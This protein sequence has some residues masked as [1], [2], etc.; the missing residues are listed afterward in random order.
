MALAGEESPNV[1]M[2][3]SDA[4]VAATRYVR[5]ATLD[6]DMQGLDYW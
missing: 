5:D 4:V 6:G 3:I 2:A 1:G